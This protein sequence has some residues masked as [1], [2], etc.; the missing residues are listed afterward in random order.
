MTQAL[1]ALAAILAV[2]QLSL[3]QG[4]EIVPSREYVIQREFVSPITGQTFV[5]DVL[6]HA[7]K[8]NS[9]DYDRCPHPAINTLNYTLVIDPVTGYVGE[10]DSFEQPSQWNEEELLTI[11]G[12]PRFTRD[13][14]PGMPWAG[15]FAWEKFENAAKLAQAAQ[16]PAVDI[17]N[18]WL[19]AAWSVRLDVIS[20]TNTFD[21]QVAEIFTKLPLCG[22]DPKQLTTLYELQLAEYWEGLHENGQLPDISDSNFSLALAWLYRSRGELLAARIWLDRFALSDPQSVTESGLYAYLDSSIELERSYLDETRG[23]LLE[24]LNS[25]LLPPSQNAGAAFLLGEVYR[26]LGDFEAAAHWYTAAQEGQ[27][28]VLNAE[29]ISH[30]LALV[31]G[32]R[33]Y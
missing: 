31:D 25:G 3:P 9:Y 30:Q 12:E 16:L 2:L 22:P 21:D 19:L 29:L 28:G 10:P 26:R 6:R 13:C 27:L 7:V 15:A 33:G 4:E 1:T 32:G 8:V 14:P 23:R 5:A 24:S 18:F 11:L 17:A 20:G